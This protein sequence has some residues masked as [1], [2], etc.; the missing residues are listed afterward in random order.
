MCSPSGSSWPVLGWTLPS[1]LYLITTFISKIMSISGVQYCQRN[2]GSLTVIAVRRNVGLHMKAVWQIINVA[3]VLE[4]SKNFNIIIVYHTKKCFVIL[5]K[6]N[7]MFEPEAVLIG[8]S[9]NF[10]TFKR[11]S[12]DHMEQ[13]TEMRRKFHWWVQFNCD[14]LN[15]CNI[16]LTNSLTN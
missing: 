2:F 5:W 9:L 1:Y 15:Y 13:V 4:K 10:A 11:P 7:C 16:N 3:K 14:Y 8:G 6:N 12:T